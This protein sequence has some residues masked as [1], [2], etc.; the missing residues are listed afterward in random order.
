MGGIKKIIV[1]KQGRK[2]YVK[3]TD[4]D[5]HTQY[6]FIKKE[7]LDKNEVE[8]N[9]GRKL[10]CFD[11]SFKDQYEKIRRLAQIIPL[12]DVGVILAQTGITHKSVV[13]DAGA[14]SGG[15]AIFLAMHAKK[16]HT[17]DIREDHI[18]IVK[19]N[20]ETLGIKNLEIKKHDVYESIPVKD[21]DVITLDLPEPWLAVDNAKKAL[22]HGGFLVSY[23]P[24]IPQVGDFVNSIRE[25]ESI[26][27]IKTIEITEREWEVDGRKIRPKT[28]GLGHSGFLT[29]SRKI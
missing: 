23:S 9:M 28:R 21:V 22:K 4:K 24:S 18:E 17:F 11:P 6:G 20:K 14:G 1:S 26:V 19:K 27:H 13:V 12:K 3:D 15:L 29:I 2:F 8:T 10:N 7:D 16:V 5:F 25:E